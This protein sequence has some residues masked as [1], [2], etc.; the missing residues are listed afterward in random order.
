MSFVWGVVQNLDGIC[1]VFGRVSG[2]FRDRIGFVAGREGV[3]FL[4]IGM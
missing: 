1:V 2:K 3:D 4:W